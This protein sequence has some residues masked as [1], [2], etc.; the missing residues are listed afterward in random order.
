M[1]ETLYLLFLDDLH[2]GD[3]LFM[4]SLARAL[5]KKQW[6]PAPVL[7]HGSGEHAQRLMESHGIFRGRSDGVL[8]IESAREHALVERALRALN[9]KIVALLTDAVVSS[10]G[11]VGAQRNI[12]VMRDGRLHAPG[13]GSL[14]SIADQGVVPVV[15]ANA[16]DD[17][18]GAT[19]E[20][21][22]KEAAASLAE[23]LDQLGRRTEIV[24]FT[25]TNLPGVMR[26]GVARREVGLNETALRESVSDWDSLAH[27]VS[28]GFPVLLTNSNRLSDPG[29]PAGS[30]VAPERKVE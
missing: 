29:G 23:R 24:F 10:V 8:E 13:A 30:R 14:R 3:V 1:V 25:T 28:A 22:L 5:S 17:A 12:F 2:G 27:L 7:V 18:S 11:V 21:A 16:R 4:Q 6:Q 15:A 9:Q 19:G 26:D 20:I